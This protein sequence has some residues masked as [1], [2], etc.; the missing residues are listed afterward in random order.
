MG[1]IYSESVVNRFLHKEQSRE[2]YISATFVSVFPHTALV[3]V[4]SLLGKGFMVIKGTWYISLVVCSFC[5]TGSY[6][7]VW[8]TMVH[9]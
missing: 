2:M 1:L 8:K 7:A 9:I 5:V 3:H 6:V 4:T